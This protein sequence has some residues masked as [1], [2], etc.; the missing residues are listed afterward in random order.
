MTN[1]LEQAVIE[2]LEEGE[3]LQ[4][5]KLYRERTGAGLKASSQSVAEIAARHA[6][7]SGLPGDEPRG[8]SPLQGVNESTSIS[9]TFTPSADYDLPNPTSEEGMSLGGLVFLGI[10]TAVAAWFLAGG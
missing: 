3:V 7:A 1:E 5:I 6:N 4:A 8:E 10:A 9:Q 2:L